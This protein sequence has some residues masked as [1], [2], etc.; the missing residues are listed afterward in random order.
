MR[1]SK[2]SNYQKEKQRKYLENSKEKEMATPKETSVRFHG[3]KLGIEG[4]VI[5]EHDVIK[6]KRKKTLKWI[7]SLSGNFF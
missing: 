3:N 2:S 5:I 4:L 1:F 7:E 6:G